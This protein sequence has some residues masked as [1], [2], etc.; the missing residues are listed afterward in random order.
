[1]AVTISDS[2]KA[3]A[4]KAFDAHMK[5][6]DFEGANNVRLQYAQMMQAQSQYGTTIYDSTTGATIAAHNPSDFKPEFGVLY[7]NNRPLPSDWAGAKITELARTHSAGGWLVMFRSK[8]D[9]AL[10]IRLYISSDEHNGRE[11]DAMAANF[12]E[13]LN[14]RRVG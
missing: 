7:Y 8:W 14:Q 13:A 12:M 5:M 1:M 9:K 10:E 2:L 11:V 6:G 4:E 3:Q